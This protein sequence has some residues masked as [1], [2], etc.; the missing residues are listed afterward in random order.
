MNYTLILVCSKTQKFP[1]PDPNYI[2]WDE[3]WWSAQP[4]TKGLSFII[5]TY[6]H[7]YLFWENI[8]VLKLLMGF[9]T[10][11]T[12]DLEFHICIKWPVISLLDKRAKVLVFLKILRETKRRK[13]EN[14]LCCLNQ[15]KKNRSG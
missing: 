7:Y 10:F 14:S 3:Q 12:I 2:V 15:V 1:S 6:Y 8:F 5:S 11:F 13:K 4:G 9:A